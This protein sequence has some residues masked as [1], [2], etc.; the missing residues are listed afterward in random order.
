MDEPIAE[1]HHA[2][3]EEPLKTSRIDIGKVGSLPTPESLQT[4][5]ETAAAAP[6]PQ[7]N[8][9]PKE[10]IAEVENP[11]TTDKILPE[12]PLQEVEKHHPEISPETVERTV[13]DHE[14]E[15]KEYE[16]VHVLQSGDP[17]DSADEANSGQVIQLRILLMN[18]LLVL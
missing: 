15:A 5:A 18:R 1:T 8:E 14:E 11:E 13:S 3:E 6:E 2:S 17:I 16:N 9:E 10:L 4:P 7:S 12:E